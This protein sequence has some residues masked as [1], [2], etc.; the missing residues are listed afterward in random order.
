MVIAQ[1]ESQYGIQKIP[2]TGDSEVV[3]GLVAKRAVQL[4][5]FSK[6]LFFSKMWKVFQL[7]VITIYRRVIQGRK[8]IHKCSENHREKFECEET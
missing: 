5:S 2:K 8:S 4:E 3:D 6:L 1:I 7:L